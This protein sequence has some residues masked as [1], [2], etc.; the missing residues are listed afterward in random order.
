MPGVGLVIHRNSPI[1]GQIP[2]YYNQV[3]IWTRVFNMGKIEPKIL[4]I[5]NNLGNKGLEAIV[6]VL[7]HSRAF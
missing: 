5:M 2:P 6:M 4:K 3:S 7:S 1:L